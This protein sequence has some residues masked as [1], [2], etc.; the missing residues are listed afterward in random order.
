MEELRW[1]R[2]LNGKH[3]EET[4]QRI[5]HEGARPHGP[6]HVFGAVSRR[7]SERSFQKPV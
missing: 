5:G 4:L 7:A 2:E 1:H 6:H 3:F